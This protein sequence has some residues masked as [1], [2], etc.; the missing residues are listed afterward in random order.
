MDMTL[1]AHLLPLNIPKDY[2]LEVKAHEAL[3][4]TRVLQ[5]EEEVVRDGSSRLRKVQM[6][7]LHSGTSWRFPAPNFHLPA[8]APICS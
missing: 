1:E 6:L 7:H 5:A 8:T 3:V 2:R 4:V